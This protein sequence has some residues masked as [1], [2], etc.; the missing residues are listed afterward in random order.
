MQ[1]SIET[2]L[3]EYLSKHLGK[4]TVKRYLADIMQFL[5]QHPHALQ[6]TYQD[7]LNYL[8]ALRIR[9]SNPNTIR[10]RL[11]AL[12]HYYSF[13]VAC[14][15][16]IDNPCKNLRIKDKTN[17]D[18]QLQDLFSSQELERLLSVHC[19]R[20]SMLQTRNQVIL[21]LLI[22]QA[23]TRQEMVALKTHH[24]NLETCTVHVKAGRLNAR[25]LKLKAKQVLLLHQYLHDDRPKLLRFETDTLLLNKLGQPESG[26]CVQHLVQSMQWLYPERKL[27]PG[28]IRQ[29][30]IAN[31]LTQGHDLR[32][33]QVFAGHKT[34]GT[35]ERYKQTHVEQLKNAILKYHPL[36]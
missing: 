14:G 28:T 17:R 5:A 27:H 21:S 18:V 12:N 23:L 2:Q 36:Q 32:V 22:Y 35:T 4:A 3:F 16:R 26:E 1:P 24:I 25:T 20:Y 10:T 15:I 11:A 31:L 13:L 7:L 6:Y 34:P 29:S 8:G 19:S 30:V 9:Y 33:V